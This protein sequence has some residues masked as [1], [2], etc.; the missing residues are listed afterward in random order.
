[1]LRRL[2]LTHLLLLNSKQHNLLIIFLLIHQRLYSLI[3][4]IYV[5]PTLVVIYS[6]DHLMEFMRLNY[7][8]LSPCLRYRL[9]IHPYSNFDDYLLPTFLICPLNLQYPVHAF[10]VFPITQAIVYSHTKSKLST[11]AMTL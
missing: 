2:Y 9:P 1:M 10:L 6:L 8:L 3:V 11:V 4:I 7:A 5:I